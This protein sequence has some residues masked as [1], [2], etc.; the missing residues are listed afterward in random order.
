MVATTLEML[1]GWP[2][3]QVR[4]VHADM[5]E[6]TLEIA[7]KTLFGTAA[8]PDAR[9]VGAALIDAMEILG[10][11]L[12]SV[13]PIPEWVPTPAH[14]RLRRSINTLEGIVL[15][16]IAEG[17][18]SGQ[19]DSTDL[20]SILLRARDDDGSSMTDRQLLDEVRTLFIAG[21]ETTA[22]A[23][24][25][26]LYLLATHP[27]VQT[28]L[29]EE[30][31][32]V[33]EGR[34]PAYGDLAR[35]RQTRNIITEALRLYPPADVIGREAISDCT[36]GSVKVRKGMNMFMSPW[37]MHRDS[38]YFQ[39][40]DRFNPGRWSD[41]FERALPRFAYFPFGGGPRFCIGQSF[42]LAEAALTLATI[43]QRFRFSPADDQ[44]LKLWP[45]ITLR[46]RNGVRLVVQAY[47]AGGG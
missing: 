5:G 22:L 25:Y 9:V 13:V 27:Q 21:H 1:E 30:L 17:R 18:R 14:R 40:P 32:C 46:P 37:V 24:T 2:K 42:A 28:N 20:L 43:C 16:I 39:E 47:G 38:R 8:T 36:I 11:R 19:A 29:Q 7:C 15:K 3:E 34:P 26:S 31:K 23:L 44:P 35:L 6:L 4:D 45:A 12:R 41:E 33:L 10:R